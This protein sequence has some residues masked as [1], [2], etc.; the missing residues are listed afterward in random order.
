MQKTYKESWG[1]KDGDYGVPRA[2]HIWSGLDG[3]YNLFFKYGCNN[4]K[5][6]DNRRISKHS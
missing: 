3:S 2:P 1:S 6:T 5:T 4:V